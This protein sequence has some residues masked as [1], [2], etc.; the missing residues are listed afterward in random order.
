M[1]SSIQR[2]RKNHVNPQKTP[3]DYSRFRPRYLIQT[4][5]EYHPSL[6]GLRHHPNIGDVVALP[7]VEVLFVQWFPGQFDPTILQSL[8]WDFKKLFAH[9]TIG[10]PGVDQPG[11]DPVDHQG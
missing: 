1:T 3:P 2:P 8:G 4:V 5:A 6:H 11:F 10:F 7:P 9:F